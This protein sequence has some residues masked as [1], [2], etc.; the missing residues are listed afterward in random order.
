M[1]H[2]LRTTLTYVRLALAKPFRFNCLWGKATR[3]NLH[4]SLAARLGT[5]AA[6]R[7]YYEVQAFACQ[8]DFTCLRCKKGAA[9]HG[10]RPI[11]TLIKKLTVFLMQI[12]HYKFH[13][14]T[15]QPI[16]IL[17]YFYMICWCISITWSIII[18]PPP[19]PLLTLLRFLISSLFL[20][21]QT[22]S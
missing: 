21:L 13:F 12:Y 18:C 4:K 20:P 14:G 9:P 2:E 11:E 16:I 10:P 15:L 7:E 17:L 1:P 22:F 6:P 19:S 8:E 3:N 5:S